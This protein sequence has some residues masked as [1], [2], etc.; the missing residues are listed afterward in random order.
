MKRVKHRVGQLVL[1][2]VATALVPPFL[3]FGMLVG[4]GRAVVSTMGDYID[5][6]TLVLRS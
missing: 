1:V 4:V 5:A 3:A 6:V 2:A